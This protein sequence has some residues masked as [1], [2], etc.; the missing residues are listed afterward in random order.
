MSLGSDMK[1][2]RAMRTKAEKTIRTVLAGSTKVPEDLRGL[3][4]GIIWRQIQ[5]STM[6]APETETRPHG[7]GDP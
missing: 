2:N 4:L 7:P 5:L 3:Y 6:A 1:R